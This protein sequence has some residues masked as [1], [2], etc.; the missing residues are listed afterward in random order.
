MAA[1]PHTRGESDRPGAPL[2]ADLE[3]LPV[4]PSPVLAEELADALPLVV[5]AGF[6]IGTIRRTGDLREAIL[7][8]AGRT[9]QA[10]QGRAT[11]LSL[12]SVAIDARGGHHPLLSV[13]VRDPGRSFPPRP[14]SGTGPGSGD[15]KSVV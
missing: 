5:R 9:D 15:R 4:H 2:P 7:P 12:S 8:A 13:C 1:D 3:D 6:E 11:P 10:V 14:R